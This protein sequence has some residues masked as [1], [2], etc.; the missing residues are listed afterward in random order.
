MKITLKNV[1]LSFP[2]LFRKAT[3]NGEETKYEATFL[4]S[5]ETQSELIAQIQGAIVE[6]VKVD[7]K[8][9]KLGPD[10]I[11]MKDGDEAEYD[12]YAGSYSLKAS[13]IKRPLVIDRDKS[14]LSEDD[15]VIYPGC[16]VNAIIELWAQNNSWGKRVNANLLGVQFYKDGQPFGGGVSAG[17]DDFEFVDDD[18]DN[19]T[20]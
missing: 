17:T 6:K 16:Y 12:G 5:K 2:S 18:D 9:V 14:P 3:F 11:C 7:L 20:F 4:I 8:G 10:K 15:N 13:S 1:R 19:L